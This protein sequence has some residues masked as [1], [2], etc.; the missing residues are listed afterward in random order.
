MNRIFNVGVTVL[1][2]F[3]AAM[4]VA[5]TLSA[6][7]SLSGNG[8]AVAEKVPVVLDAPL[9][10]DC[11]CVNGVDGVRLVMT[12]RTERELSGEVTLNEIFEKAIPVSG[13]GTAAIDGRW[14]EVTVPAGREAV[15]RLGK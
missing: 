14:L 10:L 11:R 2:A 1:L 13:G 9:G 3:A 5:M 12:N 6:L 8:A 4:V 7:A 15:F